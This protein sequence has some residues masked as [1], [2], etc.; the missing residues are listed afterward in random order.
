VFERGPYVSYVNC[1][2]PYALDRN[3][4]EDAALVF[5]TPETINDHFDIDVY[6]NAEVINISREKHTVK[7]R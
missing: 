5:H 7:P 3:I 6:V 2:I 1:A 4:P